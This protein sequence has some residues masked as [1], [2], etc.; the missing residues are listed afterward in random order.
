M[1]PP[2]PFWHTPHTFRGPTGSPTEGPNASVRMRPPHPFWYSP[3]TFGSPIG[4]SSECGAYNDGIHNCIWCGL[5]PGLLS[6]ASRG[7]LGSSW[8]YV[9]TSRRP[10]W[11]V[12]RSQRDALEPRR[13]V[14]ESS[15]LRERDFV[16]L[17]EGWWPRE[18]G[19]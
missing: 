9:A 6:F 15:W 5:S 3:Y 11:A 1:R 12:L 4:S 19:L 7:P 14:L 17:N 8:A 18:V 2:H 10:S 16:V 13:A